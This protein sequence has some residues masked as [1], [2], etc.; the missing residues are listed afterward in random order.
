MFI[1]RIVDE[2]PKRRTLNDVETDRVSLLSNSNFAGFVVAAIRVRD[3]WPQLRS[4]WSSIH[5]TPNP[6]RSPSPTPTAVDATFKVF[7]SFMDTP[8]GHL[9]LFNRK[10]C[11]SPGTP[12]AAAVKLLASPYLPTVD[13][14]SARSPSGEQTGQTWGQLISPRFFG[15]SEKTMIQTFVSTGDTVVIELIEPRL[16]WPCVMTHFRSI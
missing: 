1:A 10:H 5:Q 7:L 4:R 9:I 13:G 15:D 11:F 6:H 8:T 14:T 3:D 12:P 16:T 2:R